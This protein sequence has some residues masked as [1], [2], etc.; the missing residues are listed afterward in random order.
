MLELT[1]VSESEFHLSTTENIPQNGLKSVMNKA[2]HYLQFLDSGWH[3]KGPLTT[4]E[5]DIF[6]SSTSK[7]ANYCITVLVLLLILN[8]WMND[9]ASN[10][11][12]AS[13]DRRRL[14]GTEQ[15]AT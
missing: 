7:V 5:L 14:P 12:R 2:T 3:K 15:D 4:Y 13:P 1:Q 8:I 10:Y 6:K 11:Q 9:S